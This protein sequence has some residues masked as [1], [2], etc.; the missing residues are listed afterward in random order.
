MRTAKTGVA[1]SLIDFRRRQVALTL[2]ETG[3]LDFQIELAPMASQRLLT[4]HP[5]SIGEAQG[6]RG[7]RG[8][9]LSA[10]QR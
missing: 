2:L 7:D 6:G 1:V 4:P 5:D 8:G 3:A 10:A 9:R